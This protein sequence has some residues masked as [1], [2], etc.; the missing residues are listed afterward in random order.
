MK[1]LK[2]TCATLAAVSTFG[3]GSLATVA[4]ATAAEV[5]N[6]ITSV[7][8]IEETADS[9][10]QVHVNVTWAVPDGTAPGDTFHL[11][12]P[13]SLHALDGQTFDLRTP[14]GSA[15]VAN[16]SISGDV[17]TFTATD[18]VATHNS[19]NGSAVFSA[20]RS[21]G[22]AVNTPVDATFTSEGRTFQD[23]ITFTGDPGANTTME[24]YKWGKLNDVSSLQWGI[25]SARPY[26]GGQKITFRDT[27][28]ANSGYEINCDPGSITLW[29][30]PN[31]LNGGG[32]Q[33]VADNSKPAGF[34]GFTVESCDPVAGVVA[35]YT[36]P[37]WTQSNGSFWQ[38]E[39]RL[40]NVKVT[41][42]NKPVFANSGT[43]AFGSAT[44]PVASSVEN[45]FASGVGEGENLKVSIGDKV[46]FD[47][48]HDGRQEAGEPGIPGVVLAP[49]RSDGKPVV[50]LQGKPVAN[51]TTDSN[52][53][54][55]FTNLPVLPAGVLYGTKV[56]TPPTGMVPTVAAVGERGGDSSTGSAAALDLRTDGASDLTLDYGFWKA[57]VTPPTPKP[58]V[59]QPMVTRTFQVDTYTWRNSAWFGSKITALDD[60]GLLKF[61]EDSYIWKAPKARNYVSSRWEFVTVTLPYSTPADKW[62]AAIN[63]AT[64]IPGNDVTTTAKK[65]SGNAKAGFEVVAWEVKPGSWRDARGGSPQVFFA[66]R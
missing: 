57:P 12:L 62:M 1:S 65:A 32:N 54:Y 53:N 63:R 33:W 55:L 56:V 41:D 60:D 38:P 26:S 39:V 22:T 8:V 4:T 36:V 59:I 51:L 64:K 14:D 58:P 10:A 17:V 46:W 47:S 16:A 28:A 6:A 42:P 13:A 24:T 31:G 3:L 11:T 9:F 44:V 7:N 21:S 29:G 23:T 25:L 35:T 15:V 5:P 40:T 50:D 37:A 52:G 19:V 49:T 30:Y 45:V 43:V 61:R 20:S 48:D 18:Y 66:R 34:N 27:P 2:F